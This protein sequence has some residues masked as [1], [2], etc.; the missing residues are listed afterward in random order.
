[1]LETFSSED[2]P[3]GLKADPSE[4]ETWLRQ[5]AW[6]DF[7]YLLFQSMT[8]FRA[9]IRYPRDGEKVKHTGPTRPWTLRDRGDE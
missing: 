3:S 8:Q 9:V 5:G 1:M 6:S 2:L 4:A 7:L